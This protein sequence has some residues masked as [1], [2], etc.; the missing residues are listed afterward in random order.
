MSLRPLYVSPIGRG[1]VDIGIQNILRAVKRGNRRRL[2]KK[3]PGEVAAIP[4]QSICSTTLQR[5]HDD[6][7]SYQARLAPDGR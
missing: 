2:T 6:Q 7:R 1:G 3:L 5:G 4:R